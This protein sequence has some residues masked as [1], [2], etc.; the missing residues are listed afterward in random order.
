MGNG[1]NYYNVKKDKMEF[2]Y[3]FSNNLNLTKQS[4]I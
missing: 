1:N 2:Y 4:I 3:Q